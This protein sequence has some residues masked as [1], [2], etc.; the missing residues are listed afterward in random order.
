MDD[1]TSLIGVGLFQAAFCHILFLCPPPKKKEKYVFLLLMW[2]IGLFS[3]II[4][5]LFRLW[6]ETFCIL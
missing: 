2:I 5:L 6:S 3:R 1:V 4:V